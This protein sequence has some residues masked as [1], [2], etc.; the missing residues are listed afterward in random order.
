MIE[1][2]KVF[3]EDLMLKCIGQGRFDD[4]YHH[5]ECNL[6]TGTNTR[7]YIDLFSWLVS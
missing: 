3:E 5:I 1:K 7:H 6:S 4:N 2:K